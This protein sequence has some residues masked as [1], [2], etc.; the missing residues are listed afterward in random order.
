MMTSKNLSLLFTAKQLINHYMHVGVNYRNVNRSNSYFVLG[1]Y[2][3]VSIIN[4]SKILPILK[5]KFFF[6]YKFMLRSFSQILLITGISIDYSGDLLDKLNF[7]SIDYFFG[8]WWNGLIKNFKVFMKAR[9]R[10]SENMKILRFPRYVF[11]APFNDMLNDISAYATSR[12]SESVGVH[13]LVFFDTHKNINYI[14]SGVML[15]TKTLLNNYFLIYLILSICY[16]VFFLK[17]KKFLEDVANSIFNDLR[18]YGDCFNFFKNSVYNTEIYKT[19][20]VNYIQFLEKKKINSSFF[21]RNKSFF[22]TWKDFL[23]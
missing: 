1:L 9:V 4:L 20:S 13:S 23:D 12:E 10:P 2:R 5:K 21:Y 8:R 3:N 16:K 14:N 7:L 11:Y 6:F 17:K 22:K 18:S 19:T 15:N